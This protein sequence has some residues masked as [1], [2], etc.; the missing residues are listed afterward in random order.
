ML[1]QPR[2]SFTRQ[3]N[4]VNS[5]SRSSVF[6]VEKRMLGASVVQ[7]GGVGCTMPCQQDL[8]VTAEEV[9]LVTPS[10]S[11]SSLNN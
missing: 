4:E 2:V 6:K 7:S 1:P 8:A 10:V 9:T 5:P 3:S 11:A